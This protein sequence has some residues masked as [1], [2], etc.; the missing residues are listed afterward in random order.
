METVK[1]RLIDSGKGLSEGVRYVVAKHG[2]SGLYKGLGPTMLKSSS[3]Q[4]G[5]S[6]ASSPPPHDDLYFRQRCHK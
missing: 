1:T 5:A 4:A 2:I 6:A 3:N